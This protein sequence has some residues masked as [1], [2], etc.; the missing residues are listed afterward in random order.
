MSA[1]HYD[2]SDGPATIEDHSLTKQ[3]VLSD[4]IRRYLKQCTLLPEMDVFRMTLVDGFCGGG[5]YFREDAPGTLVL[6]SPLQMLDAV[7]SASREINLPRKKPIRFD[8]Q[9]IFVDVNPTATNHL[10]DQ[11]IQR[12]YGS[13]LDSNIWV[14]TDKFTNVCDQIVRK[15]CD[16]TR[17]SPRA[18]FFLDQYG[19]SKIP[20]PVIAG[21][22]QRIGHAEVILNLHTSSLMNYINDEILERACLGLGIADVRSALGGHSVAD[23]KRTEA[24][25][26]KL[27][28]CALYRSVV[29]GCQAKHY[30]PFFIRGRSGHGE[31]WLLHLSQK[32]RARDV[33]SRVTWERS[34]SFIHYGGAGLGM[35]NVEMMGFDQQLDDHQADNG[36][37]FNDDARSLS[38]QQLRN[39]LAPIIY[40]LKGAITFQAL[41]ERYCNECPG[42]AELFKRSVMELVDAKEITVRSVDGGRRESASRIHDS[43][44]IE[45]TGQVSMFSLG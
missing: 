33:M 40:E 17:R 9:F 24:G 45:H 12:G 34:N 25:A 1:K 32:H 43:D 2:W 23:L 21:I 11:L 36:Y 26:R 20:M 5:V 8:V 4:Y 14:L 37:L 42:D 29:D 35:L 13:R 27:I 44:I 10:R 3:E 6:G 16:H 31:Y 39:D 15:V 41:Y 30:T 18:L 38:T 22:F 7:E 19:Y 28:Q